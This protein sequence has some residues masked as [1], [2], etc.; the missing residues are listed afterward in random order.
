V[1]ATGV[2]GCVKVAFVF[3]SFFMVDTKLGRR[4]T[5]MIGSVIMCVAFYI[6]G[7]MVYMVLKQ[8][9]NSPVGPEGYVAIIMVYIFAV[10]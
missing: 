8:P 10:G 9:P 5:L 3:V 4:K 6:M 2:Y 7:G 1:L